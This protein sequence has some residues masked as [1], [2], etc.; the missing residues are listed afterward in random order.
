M[1]H[2][3]VPRYLTS[4]L[5]EEHNGSVTLHLGL[6][7]VIPGPVEYFGYGVDYYGI[8]GNVGKRYGVRFAEVASAHVFEWS[9]STQAN[10]TDASVTPIQDALIVFYP[11]ASIGLDE[12]GTIK[13][14]SH[15]NGQD[16]QT[17]LP[18]TLIRH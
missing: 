6:G 2:S 10:Y 13:A 5:V 17:E 8:D 14:F 3:N 15:V 1:T 11:D 16:V 4:V 9:S 18:V 12:V 7:E